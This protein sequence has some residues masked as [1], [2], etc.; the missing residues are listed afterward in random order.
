MS[1]LM[2]LGG[3]FDGQWTAFALPILAE[4]EELQR[5]CGRSGVVH[6]FFRSNEILRARRRCRCREAC[7][8]RGGC[9]RRRCEICRRNCFGGMR[10][11]ENGGALR[12]YF[13]QR[14]GGV[15]GHPVGAE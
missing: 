2:E 14:L 9:D 12:G 7:D 13:K 1:A 15:S 10:A 11:L 4:E 5:V 3:D 6:R 8:Q